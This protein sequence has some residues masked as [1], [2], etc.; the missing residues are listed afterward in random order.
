[1]GILQKNYTM[2]ERSYGMYLAY[3]TQAA[4]GFNVLIAIYLGFGV[5][6]G[7]LGFLI[8]LVPYLVTK[9]TKIK[10]PWFVYFLIS[11]GTPDSH[12]GIY[13]GTVSQYPQLGHA[14]PHGFRIDF[15]PARVYSSSLYG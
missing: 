4:L 11:P 9:F 6:S 2:T 8:A 3:F 10:F 12:F 15:S 7:V 1:M 14:C 5:A 13:P